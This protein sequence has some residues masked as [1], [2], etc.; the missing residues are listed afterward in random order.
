[1]F[2][3]CD[4]HNLVASILALGSCQ[5]QRYMIYVLFL[6]IERVKKHQDMP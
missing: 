1:M 6:H 4:N 3:A 2:I 5:S